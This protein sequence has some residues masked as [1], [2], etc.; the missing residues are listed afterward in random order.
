MNIVKKPLAIK[1][2]DLKIK[3][4]TVKNLE[5]KLSANIVEA[6]KEAKVEIMGGNKL[7]AEQAK[8]IAKTPL[9]IIFATELNSTKELVS[10]ELLFQLIEALSVTNAKVL[11][12]D[13]DRESDLANLG[14]LAKT[15][16][17]VIWYNP[18][19]DNQS[20]R[21]EEK[22]IDRLLLATDVAVVFSY[23]LELIKLMKSYGIVCIAPAAA[24]ILENYK[25]NEE[26]GNAFLYKRAD[27]WGIFEAI[28]RALES[29]KFTFDWQHII[30]NA[31]K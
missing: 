13:A 29:F 7:S 30:K 8:N 18:M 11:V 24:V 31:L 17:H 25:P 1:K 12:V 19:T 15:D 2:I 22:E 27:A 16:K 9:F 14:D 23:H 3:K 5:K 28:I 21:R 6:K 10:R 4:S 20:K 26:S